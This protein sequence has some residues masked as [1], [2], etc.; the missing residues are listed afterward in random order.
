M[1]EMEP[2]GA[3][4]IV[5]GSLISTALALV[6]NLA[7]ESVAIPP[8]Y[9]WPAVAV[10]AVAAVMVQARIPTLGPGPEDPFVLFLQAVRHRVRQEEGRR[11]LH[12]R[13]QIP[14]RWH[15]ADASLADFWSR[16]DRSVVS[17]IDRQPNLEGE[18]GRVLE[19]YQGISS[20]RLVVLGDGGI[21][22]TFLA[23]KFMRDALEASQA[24]GRVPV[25][26]RLGS[27]NPRK[28]PF[29]N[30]LSS[31]LTYHYPGVSPR[32]ALDFVD[33]EKIL[34]VLDGFDDM[35]ENVRPFALQ[36]LNLTTSPFLLTSRP[37]EYKAAVEAEDVLASA[38]V[39]VLEYPSIREAKEFLFR[40]SRRPIDERASAWKVVFERMEAEPSEGALSEVL[41]LPLMLF[42]ARVI[43]CDRSTND[44]NDLLDYEDSSTHLEQHLLSKFLVAT[45]SDVPLG[46]QNR[47]TRRHWDPRQ[48]RKWL[49]Y[50]ARSVPS[51]GESSG[52]IAWWKI[53]DAVPWYERL[54]VFLVTA[55]LI[56]GF[57][58]WAISGPSVGL[59]SALVCGAVGGSYCRAVPFVPLKVQPRVRDRELNIAW[60]FGVG[61]LFGLGSALAGWPLVSEWGWFALG[62]GGAFGGA[63]AGGVG[64]LLRRSEP[65]VM[66]L[67][68]EIV[69][70]LS[71]GLAGGIVV[72]LLGWLADVPP[73][74]Y[75]TWINL[76]LLFGAAFGLA[77]AFNAPIDIKLEVSPAV[78][79]AINRAFMIFYSLL[80]GLAY[81]SVLSVMLG[82]KLGIL[83]AIVIG[84]L[85]A[86]G[87]NSW[88]RWA[89]LVRFWLPLSGRV[90]WMAMAFL[91]DACDREVL[92]QKGAVWQFRHERLRLA[93]ASSDP[94]RGYRTS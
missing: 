8:A 14:L 16:I 13:V 37:D 48:A 40:A 50:F 64:G 6:V 39:V 35:A 28:V 33:N 9:A 1:L 88:G 44:P 63:L 2:G 91:E 26:F 31:Q 21:G 62:V 34:P 54:L 76:G 83:L 65:H 15:S 71:G 20:E 17:T 29:R 68:A 18:L 79:L 84:I 82:L 5:V 94:I 51:S 58:G 30:W 11:Q 89:V 3:R 57:A 66:S 85:A 59:V 75:S 80:I 46:G 70:G 56:G 78:L 32:L 7:T 36:A 4:L 27:W 52:E 38:A 77:D 90:P 72:A 42:L 43:Y 25:I 24:T 74:S 61:I 81:G 12:E 10:L 41:R 92:K 69:R 49:K 55:G 73:G 47:L 86:T 22:K 87:I 23:T 67:G 93:I 45:Y 60:K 53:G 19:F